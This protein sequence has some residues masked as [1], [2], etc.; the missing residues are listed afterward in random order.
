MYGW[1]RGG[2][3]GAEVHTWELSAA[4]KAYGS[5]AGAPWP[6]K[7][8]LLAAEQVLVLDLVAPVVPWGWSRP[9]RVGT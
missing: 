8:W 6:P 4:V 1:K 7:Q 5:G 3:L 9:R 2:Y